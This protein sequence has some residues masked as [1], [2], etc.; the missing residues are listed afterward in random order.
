MAGSGSFDF[1][2]Q[3]YSPSYNCSGSLCHTCVHFRN[4]RRRS[5]CRDTA[6]PQNHRWLC[7][8]KIITVQF[9]FTLYPVSR[10]LA[11][12]LTWFFRCTHP[13]LCLGCPLTHNTWLDSIS[14]LSYSIGKTAAP[15]FNSEAISVYRAIVGL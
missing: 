12:R 1:A 10:P 8:P 13:L 4:F 3:K 2:Y 7:R 9:Q 6:P 14:T 5:G 15:R 11:V